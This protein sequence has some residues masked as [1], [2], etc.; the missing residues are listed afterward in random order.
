M[1]YFIGRCWIIVNVSV[2]KWTTQWLFVK[3]ILILESRY[4]CRGFDLH[5]KVFSSL[6]SLT[7]RVK[8]ALHCLLD[9]SCLRASDVM[10]EDDWLRHLPVKH[11]KDEKEQQ[12]GGVGAGKE[13]GVLPSFTISLLTGFVCK[14][15][16]RE[17]ER[18]Q[19]HWAAKSCGSREEE[20]GRQR[21]VET[22]C[23]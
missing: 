16:E 23:R 12:E 15:A 21:V 11:H 17:R 22:D 10:V 19:K 14:W 4:V 6:P 7:T 8:N 2:Q 13:G 3:F 5:L 20:G 18:E 1:E 9:T